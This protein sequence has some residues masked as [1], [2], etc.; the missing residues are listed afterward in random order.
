MQINKNTGPQDYVGLQIDANGIFDVPSYCKG[1]IQGLTAS[2][3]Y[4]LVKLETQQKRA[5]GAFETV[6]DVVVTTQA[7]ETLKFSFDQFEKWANTVRE[8]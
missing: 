5:S 8:P 3:I 1:L 7:N 2:F 6:T 4:S